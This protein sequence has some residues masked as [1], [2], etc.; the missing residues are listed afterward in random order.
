MTMTIHRKMVKNRKP[1]NT[2]RR[3]STRKMRYIFTQ[4][5]ATH[6][7][8]DTPSNNNHATNAPKHHLHAQQ[9]CAWRQISTAQTKPL[10]TFII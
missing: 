3:V 10:P 8:Q 2:S 9:H 7:I 4:Y 5:S 1:H 6:F